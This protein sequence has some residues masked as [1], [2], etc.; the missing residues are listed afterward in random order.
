VEWDDDAPDDESAS[1]LLPPD[2]RLWRHPSE[3]AGP[4]P[5]TVRGFVDAEPSRP[6]RPSSPSGPP[7][8]VTVVVLTSCVSVLLTLGLVAVLRPFREKGTEPPVSA[9]SEVAK[10]A[11][12]LRP[13]IAQVVAVGADSGR[14]RVGSGV[15]YRE[16][17]L[18]LTAEHVVAG[19]DEVRVL[20]D[21]GRSLVAKIV[22]T[23]AETDIALLD[24]E[25]SSF[26]IAPLAPATSALSVGDDAITIGSAGPSSPLVRVSMVSAVGQEAG[27]EGHKLVDMIRTDAA[28]AA[29]TSGGAVVDRA[30][31]VVAIAAANVKGSSEEV[32]YA[33]PITVARSVA[34]ELLASGRVVRGWLGIEG[35]SRAGAVVHRVK[36][37]SPAEAAGL[38]KGDVIVAID[39]LVVTGMSALVARLRDTD[40]GDAVSLSV[41]RGNETVTMAATLAEPVAG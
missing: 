33:T 26:P 39:G 36:P 3:V 30:G 34:D 24:V 14:D 5:D 18:L 16:D 41:R 23:D 38:S 1:P 40:P 7:R 13:A 28:M 27:L 8:V 32:G 11:E 2:D 19:A 35:E 21:D 17:G 20:L 9:G 6:P 25:G 22:G 29:G 31:L 10:V 4:P 37:G 12:A 15:L